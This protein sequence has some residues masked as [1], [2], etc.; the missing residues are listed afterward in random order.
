MEKRD[1]SETEGNSA[2]DSPERN[3]LALMEI[4]PLNEFASVFTPAFHFY[5][6]EFCGSRALTVSEWTQFAAST[7]ISSHKGLFS[8]AGE[9]SEIA[10]REARKL[11]EINISQRYR[12]CLLMAFWCHHRDTA[13]LLRWKRNDFTTSLSARQTDDKVNSNDNGRSF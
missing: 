5:C 12:F 6:R 1:A 11:R 9:M 8:L 4:E 3:L 2:S 13:I 10:V 7:P